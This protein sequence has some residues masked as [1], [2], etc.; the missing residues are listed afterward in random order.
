MS[1][2]DISA[3]LARLAAHVDLTAIA[4]TGSVAI[5]GRV[6]NDLDVVVS[7][8]DAVAATLAAHF[9]IVHH[10]HGDRLILQVVEPRSRVR[11]D[12]FLDRFDAVAAAHQG[13]DGWLVVQ[14]AVLLAHKLEILSLASPARPVDPKHAEDARV[15]ASRLGRELPAIDSRS[16]RTDVYST[17]VAARCERCEVAR[18]PRFPLAPKPAVFDLLGHV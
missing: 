7:R 10:H 4:I 1:I 8:R 9:S 18:D 3:C 12:M 11:V 17:D 15:L 13:P 2:D 5:G 16:L 6:P 14:P